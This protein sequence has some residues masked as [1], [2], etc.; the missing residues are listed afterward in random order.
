MERIRHKLVFLARCGIREKMPMAFFKISR[1]WRSGSRQL[2]ASGRKRTEPLAQ[3]LRINTQIARDLVWC[4]TLIGDQLDS[5]ELKL[6][7]VW[8]VSAHNY[9]HRFKYTLSDVRET[10]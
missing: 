3:G 6:L 8:F 9:L 2:L 1:S 5:F 4:Q 10:G 7:R